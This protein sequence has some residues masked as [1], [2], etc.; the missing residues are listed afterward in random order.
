SGET[1]EQMK[2]L[3]RR[4]RRLERLITDLTEFA[5]A[6]HG[7]PA[8]ERVE[9][10]KLLAEV[11]ELVQPPDGF[12]VDAELHVEPFETATYPLKAVLLNLVGNA[13]K[14]HDRSTGRVEV[15]GT[16]AGDRWTFVVSDDGP[17]IGP[18]FHERVF[19]MF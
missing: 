8:L 2:I 7:E 1:R 4:V 3:R 13:I 16:D 18:Q 19:E 9:V 6:G 15:K 17:G 12:F 11:V 5:R 14:H 10:D